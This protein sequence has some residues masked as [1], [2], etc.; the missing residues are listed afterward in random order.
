MTFATEREFTVWA[1]KQAR[2]RGWLAGHL[3]N[4]RVVHRPPKG[5]KPAQTFAAPDPDAAGFPDLVLVHER[6][7]VVFVELKMPKRKPDTRQLAW[8][9]ALRGHVDVYVWW[10]DDVDEIIEVLDGLH[11]SARLFDNAYQAQT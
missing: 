7:G 3:S 10:P 2:E 5:D 4:H 11:P 9:T 8:L 1:L 6:H